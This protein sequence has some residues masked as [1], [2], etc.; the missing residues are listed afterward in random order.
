MYSLLSVE[1]DRGLRLYI[2]ECL[3]LSCTVLSVCVQCT[4]LSVCDRGQ[5]GQ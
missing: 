1:C 4:A 2:V 5:S 3:S